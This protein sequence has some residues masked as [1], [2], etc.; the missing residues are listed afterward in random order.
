[1]DATHRTALPLIAAVLAVG[2]A[3]GARGPEELARVDDAFVEQAGGGDGWAIGNRHVVY[4]L[5]LS[6]SGELEAQSL[7]L[8]GGE[9]VI[10]RSIGDA[11]FTD[12]ALSGPLGGR[13]FRFS[14]AEAHVEGRRVVL[15]LAFTRR[16][17][18]S[19]VERRYVVGPGVP[20]IEMWTAVQSRESL[21]LRD[22]DGVALDVRGRDVW[23]YLGHETPDDQGGPFTRQTAHLDD[24]RHVEF[25]STA[26]SSLEAMPWFGVSDG[27]T[28]IVSGLAW[29]GSW[30]ATIDGTAAGARLRVGL[31]DTVVTLE[32]GDSHEFPHAFVAVTGTGAGDAGA[33]LAEWLRQRRAGR[34]FPALATYNTWFTFGI[35]IDDALVRRQMDSFAAIGGE[36][37]Q[38]DAGWYPAIEARNHFDFSAGLGSWR[39]DDE[40]FPEGLGA[41]SDYAHR[42]GLKFGVWV[43]PERVDMALVG[44]PGLAESRFLAM[45]QGAYQ[46]GRENT[47]AD[48]AQICLGDG[49][50]WT[51]VRDR[52]YAFLDEARPDYVKIDLNGWLVC[53]REDHAHGRDGGNYAHVTGFYRLLEALR[54]RYPDLIIENVAGG[55][56]RLDME[57]LT[58]A[59][60]AWMDDR[61][62][63]AARVRHH[64]ESLSAIVPAGALLSYLMPHPDEP[65]MDADDFLLLSRS[66]MPG[67][68]GLAVDFRGMSE[69]DHNL[70]GAEIDVFKGLRALRGRSVA[71][72][73]T[74]PVGVD[75]SGPGWDVIEHVNPD[76]G[77][78]V[79]YA[80]RNHH[81]DRRVQVPL[82]RLQP[83]V[84]YRIRSLDRGPLGEAAGEVLMGRGLDID[85]TELSSS[86]VLILE[87]R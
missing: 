9:S 77:A 28:Q 3:L 23:W 46:P 86:Q 29:S 22:I 73:L 31:A 15:T 79:V 53:T 78:I 64:L 80:F 38:L 61:T 54:A 18:E 39:V 27:H 7:E 75:Q 6:A 85:A 41:L 19:V 70:I 63:P 40:R 47:H 83:D 87:P 12:D 81:G 30:R 21:R 37:F 42:A 13:D 48:A 68:M 62:T 10:D 74:P 24:G 52:L 84:T 55:A 69:G 1:M 33:V 57:L 25:G 43:E 45:H 65:M 35:Q 51:W 71:A 60:V 4:R 67:V 8:T 14:G 36:L 59:D 82:V 2:P 32:A 49:D 44:R 76:T 26:L 16:D 66:R 5:G 17:R 11:V 50:G 58:R 20:V 56:R 34:E 72:V